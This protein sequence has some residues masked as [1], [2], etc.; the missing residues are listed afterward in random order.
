[1]S[2]GNSHIFNGISMPDDEAQRVFDAALD[3]G[4]DTVDTANIYSEGRSEELLGRWVAGKRH[5]VILCTKCRFRTNDFMEG[6]PTHGEV[7][8]SRHSIIQAC[9]ASLRRL[10]TDYI[11]LLQLHMQDQAVPIEETLRAVEDL[12]RAGKVRYVGCSNFTAYRLVQALWAADRRN[13]T[14][15]TS[16]QLPWSLLQRDVERELV[17]A[18]RTFGLG[19]LVYSPLARGFLSGKYRRGEEPPEG[20]RLSQWRS[21][22]REYDEERSWEVL[23]A[24]TAAAKRHETTPAAVALAWLLARA[25]TSSVII[26]VRSLAQLRE[27][28]AA[29]SVR[30]SADELAILDQ[31]SEPEW[32]YPYTLIRKYEPW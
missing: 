11:D 18:A 4:I 25:E 16:I 5:R 17:P 26:G 6:R 27:N 24:V 1:M 9:E 2:L 29:T 20:S 12:V 14:S 30:L 8:L 19:V 15:L 10:S 22:F 31:Y 13:L 32:G 23:N 3:A 7:G 28:L 21:A